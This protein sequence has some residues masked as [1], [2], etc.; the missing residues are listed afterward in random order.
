MLFGEIQGFAHCGHLA[1]RRIRTRLRGRE[2]RGCRLVLSSDV[3]ELFD[4]GDDGSGFV[5]DFDGEDTLDLFFGVQSLLDFVDLLVGQAETGGNSSAS[6]PFKADGRGFVPDDVILAQIFDE[7]DHKE[8]VGHGVERASVV[9]ADVI[10][11]PPTKLHLDVNFF[12]AG[13]EP[14]YADSGAQKRRIKIQTQSHRELQTCFPR[15]A[16]DEL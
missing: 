2:G 8:R 4:F 13:C 7:H 6:R 9:G 10:R 16:P 15:Y 14:L 1:Q 12:P 11:V 3:Q 5:F